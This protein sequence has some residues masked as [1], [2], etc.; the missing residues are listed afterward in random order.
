MRGLFELKTPYD[1]LQKLRQDLK[2]LKADPT[3]P[4]KAF[5]FFVTAEHM[6]DWA[7]PG[8]ANRATR[9]ELETKSLLLQVCSHLAN[10][11][12]HFIVESFAKSGR[13]RREPKAPGSG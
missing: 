3:S 5:N 9:K 13:Q 2:A 7:Y 10:G 11:A 1:L 8:N 4:Y 12:K 6:K